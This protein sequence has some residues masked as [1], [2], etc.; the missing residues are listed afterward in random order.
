MPNKNYEKGR[1]KEYKIV[2]Q[3]KDKGYEIVQRSAGSHSPIDV[4]AIDKSTRTI[5]LIQAKPN[6][7]SNAAKQ[8][9][10]DDCSWLNG[11][12]KVI[13]EVD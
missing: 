4:F 5:K 13:F 2:K 11:L 9:I 10:I 3:Y 6:S 8:K 7:M 1:R 12:F